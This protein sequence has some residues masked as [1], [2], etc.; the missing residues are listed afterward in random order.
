VN[1]GRLWTQEEDQLVRELYQ[2]SPARLA[3]ELNRT[4][5]AIRVRACRLGVVRSGRW[6]A[7]EKSTLIEMWHEYTERAIRHA[8]RGRTWRAIRVKA[9]E[10][11]LS[12]GVPQGYVSLCD[13]AERIGYDIKTLRKIL[14]QSGVRIHRRYTDTRPGKGQR[15]YRHYVEIDDAIDAVAKHSEIETVRAAAIARGIHRNK[16]QSWLIAEGAIEKRQ[17]NRPHRIPSEIIDRV[18][19][20]YR[21]QS[22]AA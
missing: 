9:R 16:L 6:S 11:G 3:R 1:I 7:Q 21:P 20:K 15:Y 5:T 14:D 8:L 10:L 22:R 17:G 18:V 13:A 19:A 4:M 2:R 12:S